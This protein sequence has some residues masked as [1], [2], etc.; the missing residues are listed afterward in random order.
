[1]E[2]TNYSAEELAAD[3]AFRQWVMNPNPTTDQFW[4]GL[5]Q[6]HPQQ[7]A[8]VVRAIQLV[9][10]L[11][12]ATEPEALSS[13]DADQLEAIWQ[14]L[15]SRIRLEDEPEVPVK[16]IGRYGSGW[17]RW[18]VAAG[19][20]VALGVGW[21]FNRS[22]LT[23]HVADRSALT[24]SIEAKNQQEEVNNTAQPKIIHLSDGS[25]VRLLPNSRLR[26]AKSFAANKREVYLQGEAFF[27]VTKNPAR[28]FLV[29]A[30]GT[31]TKVVGTSFRVQAYEQD[32]T[33]RVVVRTGRVSVFSRK[34]FDRIGQRPDS[35][36]AGVV[37]TPNQRATFERATN[38][39]AKDL[40]EQPVIVSSS[41]A[42]QVLSFE[43]KPFA[44]VLTVLEKQYGLDI[45][46]DKQ[47][48][49]QCLITTTLSPNEGLYQRLNRICSAIGATYEVVDG[50]LII[51]STGC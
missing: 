10:Q 8:T 32:K 33:V 5:L 39:L 41:A 44:D 11:N 22:R 4:I 50:Q 18:A 38:Q 46:F 35:Q 16:P 43:D 37:L 40:I 17:N 21:W 29:F 48:L 36:V 3:S 9:Q 27:D 51:V 25:S 14:N 12:R 15:R 1:M 30:G 2:Y 24:T 13:T 7:V 19:I 49:S 6:K 42:S 28:P 23:A 20:V 26:Y 34:N 47:L 31:V 45:I